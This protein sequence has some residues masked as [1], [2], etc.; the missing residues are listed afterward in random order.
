MTAST[1][2]SPYEC[3]VKLVQDALTE[4]S[5]LKATSA[6]VLAVH[7]LGAPDHIPERVR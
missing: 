6:R 7:V 2:V 1:F 3:R 4:H 5:G